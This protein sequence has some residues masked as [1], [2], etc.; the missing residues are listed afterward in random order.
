MSGRNSADELIDETREIRRQ[1][2]AECG[3]DPKRHVEHYMEFQQRF[4]DRLVPP[5]DTTELE[6]RARALLSE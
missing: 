4:A 2:F 3:N 6:E 5:P 1:I